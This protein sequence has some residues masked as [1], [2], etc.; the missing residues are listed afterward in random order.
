MKYNKL[1]RDNIP[2]YIRK[3]GGVPASHIAGER[4]YWEKLREKLVEEAKEFQETGSKEEFADLLEVVD[5]ITEY[6]KF[7]PKEISG[8][9]GKKAA[10]RGRFEKRII[11]DES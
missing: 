1:V 8:I 6:K 7:D 2:E 3:K 5:A 9:R 10:E 11:L 4:E